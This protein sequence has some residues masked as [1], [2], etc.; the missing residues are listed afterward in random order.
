M[1]NHSIITDWSRVY[2]NTKWTDKEDDQLISLYNEG[3]GMSYIAKTM[4]RTHASINQRLTKLRK[5]DKVGY[6]NRSWTFKEDE[7]FKK[8]VNENCTL[9][10]ISYILNRSMA[11]IYQKNKKMKNN[12][13]NL[14]LIIKNIVKTNILNNENVENEA[15][16]L[17]IN[18]DKI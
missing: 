8:M 16:T 13:E 12:T 15:I 14:D 10:S 7:Q 3:V 9:N 5:L 6:K 2:A 11:S 4:S 1:D 18:I 17:T